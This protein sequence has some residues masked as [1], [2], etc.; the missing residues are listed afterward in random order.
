MIE[1]KLL[2]A[3]IAVALYGLYIKNDLKEAVTELLAGINPQ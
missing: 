3:L 2:L 1:T